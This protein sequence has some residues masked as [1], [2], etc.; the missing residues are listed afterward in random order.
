MN[1]T[2][3]RSSHKPD[4]EQKLLSCP[5]LPGIVHPVHRSDRASFQSCPSS[6]ALTDT[7]LKKKH[8]SSPL[9][10][11]SPGTFSWLREV[12]G[13]EWGLYLLSSHCVCKTGL[14]SHQKVSCFPGLKRWGSLA[15]LGFSRTS[16]KSGETGPQPS[17]PEHC[18][19]DSAGG[20][21][22]AHC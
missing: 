8:S 18:L 20:T 3:S 21:L 11:N 2:L 17:H 13:E 12:I 14:D 15:R 5:Q 9:A 4:S 7:I 1:C 16:Q 10:S 6:A 22:F 19:P